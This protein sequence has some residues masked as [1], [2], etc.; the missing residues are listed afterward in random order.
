M[1]NTTAILVVDVQ[2]GL[3]QGPG[4]VYD[5]EGLVARIRDLTDRARAAGVPVIYIQDDDVG[6]LDS[7]AWQLD[8]GLAAQPGDPRV[9][10]AFSDSFYETD[11]QRL[12]DERGARRLVV[13]GCQ[14]DACVDMTARRAVSLGYDV[15]L[16][17]DGHSTVDNRFMAAPVSIEYYNLV[18]DELGMRDGFGAGRSILRVE[19]VAEIALA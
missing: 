8:P 12:L 10:K 7:E 9:R 13:V 17:E 1:V 6:P 5:A 2:R 11:L 19:P 15:V 16:G 4:R 14:T 18:L 3:T